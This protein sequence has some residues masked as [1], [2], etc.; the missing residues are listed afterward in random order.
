MVE[1]PKP[2]YLCDRKKCDHCSYPQCKFTSD[3]I[4][5]FNIKSK[6]YEV[7]DI[8]DVLSNIAD[9]ILNVDNDLRP[10][11]IAQT[12]LDARNALIYWRYF[13]GR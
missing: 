11:E 8:V 7:K 3:V 1:K 6:Y 2:L 13:N 5:K 12:L 4:H 10:E 9:D